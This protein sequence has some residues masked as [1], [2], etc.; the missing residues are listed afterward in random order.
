MSE[1]QT[2][3]VEKRANVRRALTISCNDYER[4][5][6]EN[7]QA[8]GVP[9]HLVRKLLAI[10][11]EAATELERLD[12]W[13]LYVENR[14]PQGSEYHNDLERRSQFIDQ[15]FA[16]MHQAKKDRELQRREITA[17]EVIVAKL[18]VDADGNAV[19][20]GDTKWVQSVPVSSGIVL[21]VRDSSFEIK[22]EGGISWYESGTTHSTRAAAE[23]AACGDGMK[24]LHDAL[25]SDKGFGEALSKAAQQHRDGEGGASKEPTP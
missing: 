23:S 19:V 16:D 15:V 21:R 5:M 24:Q 10:E 18:P 25:K 9:A 6:R 7:G 11:A 8:A 20:P 2:S 14:T 17:L 1:T 3:L 22:R 13:R 4:E 12:K